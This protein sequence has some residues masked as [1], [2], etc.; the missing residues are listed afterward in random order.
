MLDLPL[1]LTFSS[2]KNMNNSIYVFLW[3]LELT[4]IIHFIAFKTNLNVNR[5][6]QG[7]FERPG[8]EGGDQEGRKEAGGWSEAGGTEQ[9]SYEVLL[10]PPGSRQVRNRNHFRRNPNQGEPVL[11]HYYSRLALKKSFT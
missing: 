10:Q 6:W 8:V 9:G 3:T 1:A 2:M 4:L 7:S 11:C 5:C